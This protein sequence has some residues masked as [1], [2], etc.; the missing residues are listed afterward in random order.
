MFLRKSDLERKNVAEFSDKFFY[1]QYVTLE[2][3]KGVLN[4]YAMLK[5]LFITI[6]LC[7]EK[8]LP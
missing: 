1:F 7:I 3:F 2:M 5:L 4:N 6:L 8:R